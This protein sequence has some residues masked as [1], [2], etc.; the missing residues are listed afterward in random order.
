MSAVRVNGSGPC[1]EA[2]HDGP[3]PL[4]PPWYAIFTSP[5]H[6]KRVAYSLCSR[7]VELYLP[8]YAAV[9]EWRNRQRVRIES[10]LFP[11]YLF[12]RVGRLNRN[13]VLSTPGVVTIVDSLRVGGQVPEQY[14]EL[15][16]NGL[17]LGRI[18][19]QPGPVIGDSVRIV[20]GVFAGI[21]GVLAHVKTHF[22]VVVTIESIN[23]RVSIELGHDEIEPVP[24]ETRVSGLRRDLA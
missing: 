22:R 4:L 9:H 14:I 24:A 18:Q 2:R 8:T 10:P 20:S 23:Q 15:L 7:E 16:R 6:E 21:E 13:L 5:R 17:E 1:S 3:L 11:S 12:A 19:P